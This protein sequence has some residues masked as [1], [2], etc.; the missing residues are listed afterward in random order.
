MVHLYKTYSKIWNLLLKKRD[1]R[2]FFDKT[3][4]FFFVLEI[5]LSIL[6]FLEQKLNILLGKNLLFHG[7]N[8]SE[9]PPIQAASA[10]RGNEV[11]APCGVLV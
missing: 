11:T 6:F 7:E 8:I 4:E 9:I 1:S 10:A 3:F 5:E 2:L